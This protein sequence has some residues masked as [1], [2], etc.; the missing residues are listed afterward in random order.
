[1]FFLFLSRATTS[2]ARA[3]KH[4]NSYNSAKRYYY[5]ISEIRKTKHEGVKIILQ[6]R[7]KRSARK[8]AIDE[9][10]NNPEIIN[11]L[12]PFEA[13]VVGILAR[14]VTEEAFALINSMCA[15]FASETYCSTSVKFDSLLEISEELDNTNGKVAIKASANSTQ[16]ITSF[17][18]MVEHP[19]LLCG[20]GS[21][22]ACYIGYQ[23]ASTLLTV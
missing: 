23:A 15:K 18:D 7:G 11:E 20:V 5:K 12:H 2:V 4:S 16:K 17:T 8:F 19:E 22:N 1:M 14:S 9:I 3:Y 6:V 21:S 10:K 13:C